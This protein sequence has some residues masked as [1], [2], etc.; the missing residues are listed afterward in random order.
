[1]YFSKVTGPY[2]N[3][4]I[5]C[6]WAD[7][8]NHWLIRKSRFK[9][10]WFCTHSPAGLDWSHC[11]YMNERSEQSPP[12]EEAQV[13]WTAENLLASFYDSVVAADIFYG[14]AASQ[15]QAGGDWINLSRRP[16]PSWILWTQCRWRREQHDGPAV[17]TAGVQPAG[18]CQHRA[19]AD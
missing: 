6:E 14:A 10:F 7:H 8:H 1:M 2:I 19:A 5:N 9:V 13:L 4:C 18:Y 17:I 3:M 16:G 15:Q 11:S 12:A